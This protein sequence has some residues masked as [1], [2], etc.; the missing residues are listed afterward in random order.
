MAVVV[1]IRTGQRRA[2]DYVLSPLRE[3]VS[4]TAHER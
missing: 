3:V 2:I 4:S 1:Q